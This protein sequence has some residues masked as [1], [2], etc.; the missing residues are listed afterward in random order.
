VSTRFPAPRLA[1]RETFQAALEEARSLTVRAPEEYLA[2]L[3]DI[4]AAA[5]VAVVYV[6]E[7]SR[8]RAYGATRWLSPIKALIQLSRSGL[9]TSTD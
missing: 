3:V 6:R 1:Q 9:A 2:R 5:G 4:C 8:C 7:L